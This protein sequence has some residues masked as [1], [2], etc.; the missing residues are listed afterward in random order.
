M[1]QLLQSHFTISDVIEQLY[2][3]WTGQTEISMIETLE[4]AYRLGLGQKAIKTRTNRGIDE[5]G[6]RRPGCNRHS[7]CYKADVEAR[8]R[9]AFAASHCHDD[10]CEDCFG[11]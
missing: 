6:N 8:A 10:C 1:P 4:T 5:N 9:G 2:S 3:E 7:D 11:C